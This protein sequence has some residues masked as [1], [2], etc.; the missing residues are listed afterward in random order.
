[1]AGNVISLIPL[2]LVYMLAQK[3]IVEGIATTGLK[4]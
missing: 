3:R 1:M 2:I 4:G